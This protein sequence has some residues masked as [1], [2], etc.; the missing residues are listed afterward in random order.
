[1]FDKILIANRGEIACRVIKTARRLG[2]RTVAVHSEADAGARHVEMADEAV[3]IGPAPAAESYLRGERVLE[4]ARRTGAQAIHPGYGFLSENAG[5]AEACAAAGVVFIGPPTEAIRVMGS[6]AESKRLMAGADV[7]LVPGYHGAAQDLDTL[8][9]EAG[10]IG[11]PVLVKASA[12]GGGKG[13]RVVREASA[14]ADA[15]AG[16]KREAKAAFGD[17][18]V[19]LEK[20]LTRPRH[21][22]IQVFADTHGRCV[23]LFERD[24]SLQR[25]HQKVI[26]EAPAPALPDEIRT[27]MGEAA[28]AAAQAVGYVGA[29]TVEFLYEDGGFYFIEMNT[30][31]QVEHP[32]TEMITGLDLVEW[33]IRVAAGEPLP[34]AQDQLVRRGHAFEA[35]LYAEDPQRDF[36]PAIGRL[37]HLRPPEEGPHVRVDTGVRQGDQVSMF[38]DPMIAK[39]IVWDE[40]RDAALR[41]LRTALAAYEV[42]GVTT[43]VAFLGAIAAH[44]AFRAMEIDTGF[45]DRHRDTLVPPPAPVPA[46]GLVLAALSVLL[47]RGAAAAH[48]SGDPHS[49]WRLVN[50]WRLNDDNHHDLRFQDGDSSRAVTLHFRPDGYEVELEGQAAVRVQRVR[51]EGGELSAVIDGVRVRAT[52]VRQGYELTILSDGAVWRLTLDDPTARGADAE[53][54]SGRLTAPMPGTVVRVL[55]GEGQAVE[56]G[57]PLML[58]EAMKME[59]TITAPGRGTVTAVNYA[60]GDQVSEGVELLVLEIEEEG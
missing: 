12:G 5:F 42:V 51:C 7:P 27:R 57:T 52:V 39:L 31:L 32:V 28:V 22:E 35:R 33:Q 56:R 54:G 44:P 20:Y 58:L 8:A 17:D 60:A 40:T 4:V 2:I 50:G 11:Y 34:L 14:F 38:Y 1:M 45:I 59:H 25:R 24:C 30:R 19:L 55:V 9:A 29:G 47:A 43:N 46:P 41:R 21:V 15:V 37:V 18:S 23:Y 16:A 26:E 36:L 13:M 6:K 48:P 53:G 10:R 3:C 49:P